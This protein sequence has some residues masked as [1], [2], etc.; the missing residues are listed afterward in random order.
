MIT[1]Q[2]ITCG[3][4]KPINHF[5]VVA[6]HKDGHQSSCKICSSAR[7]TVWRKA[8]PEQA[9]AATKRWRERNPDKVREANRRPRKR[10]YNPAARH[11][12]YERTKDRCREHNKEMAR[13]RYKKLRLWLNTY[14]LEKGCYDC[15]YRE[16]A[17][18]LHFDHVSGKKDF[19]ICNAKSISS[20]KREIAK[21]VVRC[22]NCHSVKTFQSIQRDK[23]S[24]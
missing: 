3:K 15:G 17:V 12:Y 20:A 8:H 2:C 18:A 9:R 5:Y 16:Y 21:C 6:D 23:N 1:K 4:V 24:P 11:A 10:T 13:K 7:A 22:A 14:K 19:N